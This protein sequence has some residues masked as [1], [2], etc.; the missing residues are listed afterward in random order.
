MTRRQSPSAQATPG[1]PAGKFTQ[2]RRLE[3]LREALEARPA[4]LTLDELATVL[5][6]T[7]RSVRRYIQE[8]K[9]DTDVESVQR[10][11]NEPHIVRIPPSEQRRAVPL[12]R[13]Q[14]YA[15][16]ATRRLFEV[17]RGS[18]LFE[19]I[20]LAFRQI[21]QIARRPGGRGSTEIA[22]RADLDDR[23]AFVAPAT[24]NYA[25]QG[26]IL[27]EIF[28]ALAERRF[29]VVRVKP[30]SDEEKPARTAGA[31]V[32]TSRLRFV[33]EGLFA[34]GGTLYLVYAASNSLGEPQRLLRVDRITEA[35]VVDGAK[36]LA[37]GEPLPAEIFAR[38]RFGAAFAP[39]KYT[40]VLEFD[41]RSADLARRRRVHPEQRVASAADG[42]FRLGFPAGDLDAVARWVLSFGDG[43]RVIE[44]P[45]LVLTLR[46]TLAATLA[47]YR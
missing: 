42:R 24:G 3:R 21:Q 43:V 29:L 41:A 19:E 9:W 32:T 12:R 5:G 44:P 20:D 8:L 16:L 10:A 31:G 36:G 1:R 28:R 11:P 13:T 2:T 47:K 37:P 39:E 22:L 35:Q 14:A 30:E 6:V 7:S 34:E 46:A 23:F 15:L 38:G 40:V 26:E 17:F 25:T 4:G 33:P 45:E 27:D 18:A